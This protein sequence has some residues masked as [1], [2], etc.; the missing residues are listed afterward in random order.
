MSAIGNEN[1]PPSK[2]EDIPISAQKAAQ[3]GEETEDERIKREIWEVSEE[4]NHIIIE[5]TC[6]LQT[7]QE[8]ERTRQE[9]LQRE[10][11]ERE[12]RAK[13]RKMRKKSANGTPK[14][15][16]AGKQFLHQ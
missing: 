11:E 10:K 7:Q 8:I 9:R 16:E 4:E 1:I 2:M 5:Q 13:M 3:G 6:L 14:R 12:K 15:I